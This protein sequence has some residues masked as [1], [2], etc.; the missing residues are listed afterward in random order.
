MAG[1]AITAPGGGQEIVTLTRRRHWGKRL[2]TELSVLLLLLLSLAVGGLILL[3]T[4]PGHRFIVDRLAQV[5]TATGLRIRV[6][7]I[8]GSI[9]GEA[10]LKG[11]SVSDPQGVFLTSPEIMIDWAPGAWLYNNLHIDRLE[12]P[13]VRLDRLPRLR[14]TGRKGPILP[15][16][17]IHIGRLEIDRLELARGVTGAARTGSLSGE[18]DIRAGRAMIGLRLAMLD[19][20]RVAARLDA[21]PDRDRFDLDVRAIAPR[22]GLIPAIVGLN[23]PIDLSI[24]GDGSWT[25]WRGAARLL[26][27]RREAANLAL[28]ADS[29]RYRLKGRLA[30]A[31][32]LKGKMQRL[33]AP[34]VRVEG[35]AT[36]RD[37]ILDG[38]LSLASP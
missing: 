31:P 8:E 11:V 14:K 9:Y 18:A 33:T 29:G 16:F 23:R 37:R 24:E 34:Q 21:E 28:A 2:L 5:E 4:A 22:D 7:R 6:A 12:S 10:R 3:D 32:F 13:L 25:R 20:D 19:G 38:Q 27:E 30:P 17:D 35:G 1:T 15:N 26:V 36:F